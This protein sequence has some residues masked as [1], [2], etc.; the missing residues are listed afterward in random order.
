[1]KKCA[2][3][4]GEIDSLIDQF[5]SKK[6]PLC[7]SCFLIADTTGTALKI[8]SN[9]EKIIKL[10]DEYFQNINEIDGLEIRNQDIDCQIVNLEIEIDEI[11]YLG[12]Q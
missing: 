6:N 11:K 4:K 7:F 2:R 1:M 9:K 12:E 10:H 3:C 5:G 8:Q